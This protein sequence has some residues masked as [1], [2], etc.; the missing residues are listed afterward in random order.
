MLHIILSWQT[1]YC[2]LIFNLVLDPSNLGS[3][4]N[5]EVK[6]AG[7]MQFIFIFHQKNCYSSVA[8][9]INAELLELHFSKHLCYP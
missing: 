5:L 4:V 8:L 7:I 9:R 1:L 2:I 6:I 3:Q